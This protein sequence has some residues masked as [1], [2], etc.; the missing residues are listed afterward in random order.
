MLIADARLSDIAIEA[1][2][3]APGIQ[4]KLA[5]GGAIEG[6]DSYDD[7]LAA[8]DGSDIDDPT[9]GTSMLYTSGTTGR[10]KGVNRPAIRAQ[11][12]M[13]IYGYQPG[14]DMHLCT[15]P[16]YHAAPLAFSLASPLSSGAGVVL[17]D[18]WDPEETLRLIETHKVTHTHMVPTMFVRML[19]LPADVRAKYDVSSMRSILHGAAPCPVSVKQE[20]IEWVGPIVYE[21][22]A[23]TEG[24]G[25]AVDSTTWLT[26]P[27]TVGK[28]NPPEHVVIGDD[29]GNPLPTG[30]VGLVYLKAPPIG[31]F[32]YYKDEDKT[33]GSYRG[34]YF[35]L[36]DMGYVDEDGFLFL[37]DRTANL[38]ISG[39]VNIYPAEVDAVLA[40]APGGVGRCHDR[41]SQRRV[42][43]GSQG[44]RRVATRRRG[45]ARVGRGADPVREGASREL[46]VPAHGRLRRHVAAA[47]QREDLQAAHP[48][49]VQGTSSHLKQ[50]VMSMGICDGRVVIVTGAGRGIGKG[51]AIEFARQ[52][53]KVV[54]NDL[55][56]EVD[57]SGSSTGP[58]GEVVDEIRAMGGEAIANGENV[59]D[60][61]GAQRLINTAIETFGASTRS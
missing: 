17:M 51:H 16:L 1:A 58:A 11:A 13:N 9:V 38:I 29:D 19:K 27:G 21:Y 50:G 7:A 61:E 23:A 40:R 55:G 30:S 52:G 39:G 15:G 25:T 56:A 28:V 37:T 3:H 35:T 5:V 24:A 45:Y 41:D 48:R 43:R 34:D 8:E 53:A 20:L 33:A 12:I 54:V 26:K 46:Q 4:V 10:P 14:V 22:Y 44:R 6:F 18:G 60:W 31:R 36:G 59:A 2:A 57:G 42:G 47:G 49:S 32:Q